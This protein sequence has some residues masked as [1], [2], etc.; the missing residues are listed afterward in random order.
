MPGKTLSRIDLYEAVSRE[1]GLPRSES[2]QLVER[3]LELVSDALVEDKQLKISSF[4]SFLVR[5]T[6]TRVGRN[7]KTGEEAVISSRH[8][9][10]FRP[11]PHM[12]DKVSG[13]RVLRQV[14]Y[15]TDQGNAALTSDTD[16]AESVA[17]QVTNR[18]DLFRQ[19]EKRENP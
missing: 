16:P 5:P 17:N 18:E 2:A 9:L 4:G 14:P 6:P 19:T 3:V 1:V 8:V 11:S 15:E 10:K 13:S 7:P 12:K